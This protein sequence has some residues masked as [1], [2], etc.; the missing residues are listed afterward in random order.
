M[1]FV[2]GCVDGH[3]IAN[4]FAVNTETKN[5]KNWCGDGERGSVPKFVIWLT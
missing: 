3:F 4:V 5:I 1:S 2:F